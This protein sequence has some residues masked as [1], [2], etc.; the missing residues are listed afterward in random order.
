MVW[1]L[2]VFLSVLFCFQG[3]SPN[4]VSTPILSPLDTI[5]QNPYQLSDTI[6]RLAS[7]TVIKINPEAIFTADTIIRMTIYRRVG[8]SVIDNLH[9]DTIPPSDSLSEKDTAD[10]VGFARV[11]F[12][13]DLRRYGLLKMKVNNT[14]T[15]VFID[16]RRLIADGRRE[17]VNALTIQF[18]P[19]DPMNKDTINRSFEVIDGVCATKSVLIPSGYSYEALISLWCVWQYPWDSTRYLYDRSFS[20]IDTI[21]LRSK[22]RD[23]LNMAFYESQRFKTFV[24]LEDPI[25]AWTEN[26][27]YSAKIG[28][29]TTSALYKN[30]RL[31]FGYLYENIGNKRA[32]NIVIVCDTGEIHL[33]FFS[34][35]KT[36]IGDNL[37]EVSR[38]DIYIDNNES[39]Y[40]DF[41]IRLEKVMLFQ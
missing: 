10:T 36:M 40:S 6:I 30:G 3:C 35:L 7:D 4:P 34:D 33:S 8:E 22:A 27:S 15:T 28:S 29:V 24:T 18:A 37:V 21:N 11:E 26:K 41:P 20:A 16:D 31:M 23:T 38:E 9:H 1:K 5:P 13:L 39:L 14:V 17:M 19:L 12:N 25:G 2:F 32:S